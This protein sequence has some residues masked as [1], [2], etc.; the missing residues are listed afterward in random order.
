MTP[1]S[2]SVKY[3]RRGHKLRFFGRGKAQFLTV[4]MYLLKKKGAETLKV[5]L[6]GQITVHSLK[7]F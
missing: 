1:P 6:A 3:T 2:P 7:W 5:S 4:G